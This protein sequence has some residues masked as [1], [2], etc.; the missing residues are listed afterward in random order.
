MDFLGELVQVNW[1]ET[2]DGQLV[3]VAFSQVATHRNEEG[4]T[5][6]NM[7]IK[8]ADELIVFQEKYDIAGSGYIEK[9]ISDVRSHDQVGDSPDG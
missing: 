2:H 3:F 8:D 6:L 4:F 9:I 7:T 1:Q 5:L